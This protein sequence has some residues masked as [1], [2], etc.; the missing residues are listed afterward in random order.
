MTQK[1]GPWLLQALF[2]TS[3]SATDLIAEGH[4]VPVPGGFLHQKISSVPFNTFAV[5]AKL[6]FYLCEYCCVSCADLRKSS[7]YLSLFFSC[8]VF[9]TDASSSAKLNTHLLCIFSRKP[10]RS[11]FLLISLSWLCCKTAFIEQTNFV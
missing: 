3:L 4:N 5:R 7:F 10:K 6:F 1:L 8:S 9:Q 2:W 11:E